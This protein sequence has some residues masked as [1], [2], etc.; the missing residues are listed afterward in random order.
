MMPAMLR[1]A[2][3]L[4]SAGSLVL[5]LATCALWV[6]SYYATDKV[7]DLALPH[8]GRWDLESEQGRVWVGEARRRIEWNLYRVE[9][10]RRSAVLRRVSAELSAVSVDSVEWR[11]KS[12]EALAAAR[13]AR[14]WQVTC[15]VFKAYAMS[16]VPTGH[17]AAAAAVPPGAWVAGWLLRRRRRRLRVARG[18][19]LACGYDLRATPDRCPDCGL[20]ALPADRK[21]R[22]A[23]IA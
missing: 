14:D 5:G 13:S 22:V 16:R 11:P 9:M 10:G 4:A 2:F 21:A 12:R 8:T 17:V 6:R 7:L 1:R 18:Q 3:T 15:P 23:T 20:M 19:C